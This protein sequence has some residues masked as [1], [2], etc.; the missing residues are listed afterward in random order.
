MTK[1]ASMN[2]AAFFVKRLG[3]YSLLIE[4]RGLTISPA[5]SRF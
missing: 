4:D 5:S 1:A 2:E 3:S